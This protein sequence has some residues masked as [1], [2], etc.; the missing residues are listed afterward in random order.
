MN[1]SQGRGLFKLPTLNPLLPG[2][3]T[4]PKEKKSENLDT[5]SGKSVRDR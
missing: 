3:K 1:K 2:I 5:F 4:S